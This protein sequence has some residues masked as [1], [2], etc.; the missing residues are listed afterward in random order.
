MKRIST[1]GTALA[2]LLTACGLAVLPTDS[3]AA[4]FKLNGNTKCSSFG[5][6]GGLTMDPA[7]NISVTCTEDGDNGGT[8]VPVCSPYATPQTFT[9]SATA[10][11][12]IALTANCSGSPTSYQWGNSPTSPG[13]VPVGAGATANT[14]FGPSTPAG[15]YTFY[16]TASNASGAGAQATLSFTVTSQGT[17]QCPSGQQLVNGVCQPINNGGGGTQCNGTVDGFTYTGQFKDYSI[18]QGG[19]ASFRLPAMTQNGR[20]VEMI[21]FQSTSTPSDLQSEVTISDTCGNFTVPA[22]CRQS[23]SSWSSIDLWAFVGGTVPGYCS[24]TPG[25]T[26]YVN[27]RNNPNGVESCK[28]ASC[29]QRLQYIGDLR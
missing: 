12:V 22:E 15:T 18:L 4:S 26:Y 10:T 3:M 16:V 21:A 5:S 2:A 27:V 23:G 17:T 6:S 1:I 9:S 11:N 8:G 24:L 25:R 20:H 13:V 28:A 29:A 7:G 14:T 19:T